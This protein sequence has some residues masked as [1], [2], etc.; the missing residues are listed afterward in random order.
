MVYD[1]KIEGT[2]SITKKI[3]ACSSQQALKD[4]L[5]LSEKELNPSDGF[6]IDGVTVQSEE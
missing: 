3:D 6:F 5:I 4:A 2:F 1:V